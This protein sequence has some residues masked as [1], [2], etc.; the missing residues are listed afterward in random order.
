M[1]GVEKLDSD[2]V[3]SCLLGDFRENAALRNEFLDLVRRR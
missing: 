3:T 1:R 2:T